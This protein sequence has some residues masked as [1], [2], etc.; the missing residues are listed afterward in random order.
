MALLVLWI[1]ASGCATLHPG[2]QRENFAPLLLHSAGEEKEETESDLLGPFLTYRRKGPEKELA[3]RPFF[4]WKEGEK[5]SFVEYLYPLGKYHRDERQVHSYLMPFFNH[6]RDL[7]ADGQRRSERNFFLVFWGESEEG[8]RYGGFFPLYGTLKKRLGKDEL[9]FVLWPIYS[10]SREGENRTYNFLWPIFTFSSGGGRE[11]FKIWPLYGRESDAGRF[12]KTYYLWPIFHFQKRDM[13]TAQPTTIRMVFPF[14]VSY[15]SPQRVSRWVLW[16]FFQYTHAAEEGYTQWNFP[17][18][19]LEWARGEGKSISR[20]FPFYSRKEWEGNVSG[21]VLWP[22]YLY[23]HEESETYR[24]V[25][26]RYLLLSKDQTETWK[27]E[28]E[29]ARILR[30]WPFFYYE[31]KRGGE[32]HFYFPAL[33]PLED[34]GAERNWHPLF[35]L[36]DYRRN[37]RGETESKF[38]WGLYLHRETARSELYELTFLL[39]RYTAEDLYYFGLLRG[40]LEYRADGRRRA[41]RLFYAPRPIEWEK[42]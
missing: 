8:E 40:L 33:I 6:R 26:Q 38:L 24:R 7:T 21:Y 25:R 42:R 36:Y 14:Y 3:F 20:F 37:P 34:E 4:Y 32:V 22:L 1:W 2:P 12:E 27:E 29:Q 13:D 31:Q 39:T 9:S 11:A 5:E 35:R 23:D 18:P 10:D 30:L 19:F 28:G 16:P 17:W 15:S 41:L